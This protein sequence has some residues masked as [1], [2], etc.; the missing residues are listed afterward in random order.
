MSNKAQRIFYLRLQ[1]GISRGIAPSFP[2]VVIEI[3]LAEDTFDNGAN[4]FVSRQEDN[5]EKRQ[6]TLSVD[7]AEALRDEIKALL[8]KLPPADGEWDIYQLDKGIFFG[9]EELQWSNMPQQGCNVRE[10]G[11]ASDTD[12]SHFAKAVEIIEKAANL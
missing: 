8:S 3:S 7:K 2:R 6:Q 5:M 9:S 12:K 10:T 4:V 1:H 11:Q